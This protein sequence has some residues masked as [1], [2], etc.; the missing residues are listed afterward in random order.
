MNL[1]IEFELF[2]MHQCKLIK[3]IFIMRFLYYV[4]KHIFYNINI[5]I[6]Y[7]I[8]V[9]FDKNTNKMYIHIFF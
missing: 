3:Y 8:I 7:N 4:R 9:Y 6:I 1:I 2:S 5:F